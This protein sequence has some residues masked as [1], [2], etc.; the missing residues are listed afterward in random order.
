MALN[1][2]FEFWEQ[3]LMSDE[4]YSYTEASLKKRKIDKDTIKR[5]MRAKA[6]HELVRK[7]REYTKQ[8]TQERAKKREIMDTVIESFVISEESKPEQG[9]LTRKVVKKTTEGAASDGKAQKD[10]GQDNIQD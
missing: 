7:N 9:V 1:L 5:M 2:E 3:G 6:S 4:Y 10:P 8:Q